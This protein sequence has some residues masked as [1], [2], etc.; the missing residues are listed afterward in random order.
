MIEIQKLSTR[1]TSR[2]VST[3]QVRGTCTLSRILHS[4]WFH[5]AISKWKGQASLKT[6]CT[7]S[8]I[9]SC[10]FCLSEG[11]LFPEDRWRPCSGEVSSSLCHFSRK[12]DN[13]SSW[14][15]FW[16]QSEAKLNVNTLAGSAYGYCVS[17]DAIFLG[18]C[19]DT[20]SWSW[21]SLSPLRTGNL[22][23]VLEE[24]WWGLTSL[25][26]CPGNCEDMKKIFALDLLCSVKLL[27]LKHASNLTTHA[28]GLL[29]NFPKVGRMQIISSPWVLLCTTCE[30][31][32]CKYAKECHVTVIE[33][34]IE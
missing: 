23:F 20:S 27:N 25:L 33:R 28:S 6:Y 3:E 21:L 15:K 19:S 5:T 17:L 34:Y 31:S 12:D 26:W 30:L 2:Q 1:N 18:T 16:N 11:S 14:C 32:V 10:S 22:S 9:D 7:L 24:S 8:S 13:S 29:T 4:N